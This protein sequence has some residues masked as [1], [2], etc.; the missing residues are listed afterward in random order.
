MGTYTY[1]P[2][3]KQTSHN[4]I[5]IRLSGG[6]MVEI[7]DTAGQEEF[8]LIRKFAVTKADFIAFVYAVDDRNSFLQV[9]EIFNNF[10]FLNT[11]SKIILI[12]TKIDLYDKNINVVNKGERNY[13][14]GDK[15]SLYDG[16]KMVNDNK[17]PNWEFYNEE[18]S[19]QEGLGLKKE[20][21]ADYFIETSAM[22]GIGAI[23]V[24]TALDR[25]VNPEIFEKKESGFWK[26]FY[27]IFC[28]GMKNK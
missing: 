24:V 9:K 5:N 11:K 8:H 10:D 6:K 7:M 17:S 12:S 2:T 4:K 1:T 25:I 13:H 3:G 16:K 26:F 22:T 28:C 18:V 20:I 27:S 15:I 21:G 19:Y 14:K 23:G